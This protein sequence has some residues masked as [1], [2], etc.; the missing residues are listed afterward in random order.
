MT[1]N[2]LAPSLRRSMLRKLAA[3]LSMLALASG[4]IAY[5]LAWQY[6]ERVVD[7]SLVD[8]A[9][10][11]AHQIRVSGNDASYAVPPLAR[12][13][14]DDP[15]EN[16][17]YRITLGQRELAGDERLPLEGSSYSRIDRADVFNASYLDDTVRI[18]RV[19][20]IDARG[21]LAHIEVGQSVARR[22]RL[23]AE[24]LAAIMVPLLTLLLAGWFIVWRVVDQHLIPLKSLADSLNRQTHRSLEAL[25]ETAVP[26]EIRPLTSALNA[27]LLRL[28]TALDSQRKFIAD[29]AHQLR[30]PL[31]AIKL[32][33]EQAACAGDPARQAEA[34][35][36]LRSSADRA[37]RLSNQ[38]L[39]LARAEPGQMSARFVEIDLAVLAF[40]VGA[41]WVP[42]ALAAGAD[43]GFQHLDDDG[44]PLIV[45][46]NPM[47]LREVLANLLDNALK[48]VPP[49]RPAGDAHITVCVRGVERLGA[50]AAQLCV[51]DNGPGVAEHAQSGLFERFF[52]GD[53]LSSAGAGLGLAIVKDIVTLHSGRVEYESAR[54][55]GSRFL[56][57][58]PLADD[59]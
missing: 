16:L 38:L 55:C 30:T 12:A 28:G 35:N 37:V 15:A 22:Y 36:E 21:Q 47:L 17:V 31:T 13:M 19:N 56:I 1:R 48:Y 41:E 18:A 45:K 5:W 27:L 53:G 44:Q 14:F 23:A 43:L 42:R 3:P 34:V 9:N 2:T 24:F 52:R 6:T 20:V 29:A 59:R 51:E 49:H 40:E 57:T 39:S 8:L 4:L 58:L 26:I 7:R 10:A 50:A 25:D 46:G 11:V 33:A 32:H 54:G